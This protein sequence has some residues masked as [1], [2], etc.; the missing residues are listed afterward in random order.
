MDLRPSGVQSVCPG[1]VGPITVICNL[2]WT[3]SNIL[4][5]DVDPNGISRQTV[6]HRKGFNFSLKINSIGE[7]HLISMTSSYIVTRLEVPDSQGLIP[8]TVTCGD[9][10][11]ESEEHLVINYNGK[12]CSHFCLETIFKYFG[13]IQQIQ[14][15]WSQR[16]PAM[17]ACRKIPA[18]VA[19]I[20]STG[21]LLV[22][23]HQLTA[24]LSISQPYLPKPSL[25]L[26]LIYQFFS[27]T[28]PITQSH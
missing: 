1:T 11:T 21:S 2:T 19:I 8:M 14:E 24:T 23:L 26:P 13:T 16:H 6:F 10:S 28:I 17:L 18:S 20:F 12:K 5:W 7:V 4:R 9:G 15:P 22:H 3:S 27:P 25:L